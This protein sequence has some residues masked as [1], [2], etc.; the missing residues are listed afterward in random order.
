MEGKNSKTKSKVDLYED[1]EEG[2]TQRATSPEPSRVSMKSKQSMDSPADV[3]DGAVT[4]D[5]SSGER[6]DLTW[7]QSGCGVCEQVLRDSV[8]ITCG[9]SFCR[10]CINFYSNQ[11]RASEQFDCP[12]CRKRSRTNRAMK[13]SSSAG[14]VDLQE[15][16]GDLHK[17]LNDEIQ[18]VKNQHKTSM[19]NNLDHGGPYRITP[20]LQKYA[21]DL[22]L[23]PNTANTQL[24]LSEEN[25]KITYVKDHQPYPDHPERFDDIPQVLCRESLTGR[26]YWVVEWGSREDERGSWARIAVAYKGISRKEGTVCKLGYNDKSWCL[27][28]T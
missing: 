24:I 12:Q 10:Q 16:T 1:Q 5:P 2:R 18:R 6:D 4:S 15:E 19:K 22:T 25:K 27:F 13:R 28:C 21:C 20:G 23:D 14:S 7:V 26:C 3:S 9:H 11:S 8:S 17:P